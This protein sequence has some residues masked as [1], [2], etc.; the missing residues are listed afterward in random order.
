MIW[1]SH[2][3]SGQ[4]FPRGS[5]QQGY[6]A[7]HVGLRSTRGQHDHRQP[8]GEAREGQAAPGH[9]EQHPVLRVQD[10]V[11]PQRK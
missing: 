2:R 5:P 8:D 11:T 3:N 6:R 10:L 9:L 4:V 7:A 1:H